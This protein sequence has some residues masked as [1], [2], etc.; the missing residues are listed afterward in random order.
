MCGIGTNPKEYKMD[1]AEGVYQRCYELFPY[2]KHLELN[3]A[4]IFAEGE[5]RGAR[6]DKLIERARDFPQLKLG[7]AT[8][9]ILLGKA[10]IAGIVEK[11]DELSFSLDSA[12]PRIYESIRL[13]ARFEVLEDNL[14]RI[15]EMKAK[16]GK[17]PQDYPQLHFSAVIMERTYRGLVE[18]VSFI[19]KLGGVFLALRPLTQDV[20]DTQWEEIKQEDI[21]ADKLRVSEY[22]EIAA[23]ARKVA[24]QTGIK[25]VDK[26]LGR[27]RRKFPELI[28]PKHPVHKKA[29]ESAVCDLGWKS[30]YVNSQGLVSFGPCSR[31]IIGDLNTQSAKVIWN[32]KTARRERK[33]LIKGNYSNCTPSRCFR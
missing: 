20:T 8:N 19:A 5:G 3:G 29:R 13:G 22:L 14:K 18:L 26:T 6:V 31:M 7:G 10:R 24:D 16:L 33:N 32:S 17:G 2:L 21:F 9:G 28:K 15:N 11:F 1:L 30:F 25:I 12:D 27:I 23:K 4:E